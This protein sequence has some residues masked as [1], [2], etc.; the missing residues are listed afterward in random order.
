MVINVK[1]IKREKYIE[2][3]ISLKNKPDIKIITGIRRS[4]KSMLLNEFIKYI[5]H[6]E[7]NANIIRVDFNSLSF[8]NLKDYH[9]LNEYI[10]SKYDSNKTNYVFVDEIQLCPKFELAINDLYNSHEFDI[11]ITGSNAFLLSSDLATLFTGRYFEIEVLPFSFKEF[12]QYYEI[13]NIDEA[14]ER[15]TFEGGFAGSY[16]YDDKSKKQEYISNVLDVVVLKDIMK[17]NKVNDEVS[18]E[19]LLS[20]LLDNISNLSSI[21]RITEILKNNGVSIDHK[22]IG[23]Y[24]KYLCEGYVFYKV[25]R[26]DIKGNGYLKT[27]E[28]Y[29]VVD[30]GFRFAKLGFRYFDYG[31]IYENIVAIELIRRGYN[32][33]V[34]KLYQKEIDFVAMK[35]NEKIYIQVSDNISNEETWKRELTPLFQIK[36]A[37]PKMIITNTKHPTYDI[38]GIKVYDI[39]RWLIEDEK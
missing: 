38:A 39:A 28:K 7:S 21:N 37:Y 26:Y 12:I 31:R 25:K 11:Y 13:K 9:K 24:L 27:N 2:Q 18:M 5:E 29:Y 15:Y 23:N 36:D 14:F 20:F 33:Y 3:L 22:T 17:K 19:N 32:V 6:D 35:G 10:R 4:G 30:Q 8:D 34:G 1:I 16:L